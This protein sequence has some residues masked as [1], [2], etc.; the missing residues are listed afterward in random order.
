MAGYISFSLDD[1]I[2]SNDNNTIKNIF[3]DFENPNKDV[4]NFLQKKSIIFNKSNFAKTKLILAPFKGENRLAG[5]YTLASRAILIDL[6]KINNSEVR[7]AVT[8]CS[9]FEKAVGL[10]IMNAPLIAQLGKNFKY[11]NIISGAELLSLALDDL[12][13]LRGIVG[14]KVVYLECEDNE[15]LI[16]FYMDNGFRQIGIRYLDKDEEDISGSYLVQ[17]ARKFRD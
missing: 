10:H 16:S 4:L 15:K 8:N 13:I 12:K 2:Q 9:T 17:M 11:P 1:L 5:Y 6:K 7:K 14:A 3:E